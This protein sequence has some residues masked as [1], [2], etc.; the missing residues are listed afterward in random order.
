MRRVAAMVDLKQTDEDKQEWLKSSYPS[1]NSVPDYPY[2]LALSL[3][4]QELKKLGLYDEDIKPGDMFH[5]HAM[6]VVTSTSEN[7][8]KDQEPKC[9]VELQITHMS[10]EDE[11]DE[12]EEDEES[13]DAPKSLSASERVSK[14]Y[15][16]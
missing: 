3:S 14:L 9:R 15:K 1:P 7:V 4:E 12:D 11:A 16:G 6:A 8:N 2:G 5:F 10:A 13:E